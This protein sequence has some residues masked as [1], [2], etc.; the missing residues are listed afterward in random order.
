MVQQRSAQ[1]KPEGECNHMCIAAMFVDAALMDHPITGQSAG[2]F[3]SSKPHLAGTVTQLE[4]RG[5]Q[6]FTT[7]PVC[8]HT[9]MGW[10]C[11]R[12]RYRLTSAGLLPALGLSA[13]M[14]CS[15]SARY[16]VAVAGTDPTGSSKPAATVTAPV[17]KAAK[18]VP[19]SPPKVV[20]PEKHMLTM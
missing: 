3:V 8:V 15:P 7:R 4:E 9:C 6:T 17:V 2:A 16:A 18:A 14:R 11:Q 20:V 10:F 1:S 13:S 12:R 19:P 5:R